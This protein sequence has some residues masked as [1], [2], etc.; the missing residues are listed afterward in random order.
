VAIGIVKHELSVQRHLQFMNR[1]RALLVKCTVVLVLAAAGFFLTGGSG[2]AQGI[3]HLT[4]A[5]PGGM[6]GMPVM[7]GI[8]RTTNGFALT[9]DGPSGYYHLYQKSG[10]QDPSWQ[11]A[12]GFNLNRTTTITNISSNTFFRVSGPAPRYAGA[13]TCAECHG[14]VH[15]TE[16][17]TAHAQ[18][19]LALQQIHQDTNSTCLPC[20]SV[21]YGLPTGFTDATHTLQ[22]E[23]VQCEN[24]HGPAAN[25]A[26]NPGDPTVVPRVEL[27]AQVCGGCH[28]AQFAPLSVAGLHPSFFEDWNASPHQAVVPD[29]L[30]SMSSSTNSI[31]SCGRCHSGSA[32]LALL[33]GQNPS[34]TLTNDFNVA[35]TCAI[36]HDPHATQVWTNVLSGVIAFTNSLTGNGILITNN[37][38]GLVYTNQLRC[39]L[40]STNDFYLTTSDVFSNKYDPTI[41]VCAQCHNDRGTAWTDTSRSPHHS[42]QYNMLLGTVGELTTGTTPGLPSTHSRLEMQ[43]VECHMQTTNNSSGHTFAVVTYQLCYNCHS[44][45]AGLVQFVTSDISNQIQQTKGLLNMWATNNAP[46]ALQTKYGTLA[47]EYTTPGDLSVG[48]SGPS[49]TEQNSITNDIKKARFDL[50]LVLYDGSY[51]VHNGLYDI[52]LLQSAQNWID[53]QLY[54]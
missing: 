35:I 1:A 53:G 45:P 37:Q 39:A 8:Q 5:Q 29:V 2:R 13:Q 4:I 15:D 18:A 28:S 10:L 34:A 48:S 19:F 27:A 36:C 25:H 49:A 42:P 46:A 3:P 26:A 38:L 43:C 40:S 23:G 17:N 11:A 22:L 54:Q 9:W 47:W 7:T 30:A 12:G 31:S 41:N 32:R 33:E 51:G 6:P 24:C 21:G 20:H 50:Y 14:N 16:M 52:Q 44:D